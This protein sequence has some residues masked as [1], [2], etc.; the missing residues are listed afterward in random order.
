M[1]IAIQIPET[2]Y[3]DDKACAEFILDINE[4]LAKCSA[5]EKSLKEAKE[6]ASKVM[7]ER[8]EV[9]GQKHFA[10]DFGTFSKTTKTQVA[11]PT[12]DNGGKEAAVAWLAELLERGVIDLYDVMN[13]QQ[14]RISVEA[15]L[16]LEQLAS[17][18]NAN[19]SLDTEF[20]PVPPSPFNK[21]EQ[22]TLNT[23]RKR[24]G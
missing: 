15:T 16:A 3:T 8:L 12:A 21:Y 11:F 18:Y 17:D 10:Y 5:V 4:Q 13:V 22:T 9:T 23:P 2:I 6:K 7:L 19:H 1:S 20:V 14:S 24:K